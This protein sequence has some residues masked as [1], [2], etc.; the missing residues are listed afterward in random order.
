MEMTPDTDV[1]LNSKQQLLL[2]DCKNY[3][4]A[5]SVSKTSSIPPPPPI[6]KLVHGPPGVGK[7]FVIHQIV[8]A[9]GELGLEVGCCAYMGH[10]AT[11]MPFGRTVYNCLGI[12]VM[13]SSQ[14]YKWFSPSSIQSLGQTLSHLDRDKIGMIIIDEISMITPQFLAE[15]DNNKT[16]ITLNAVRS[17]YFAQIGGKIR[18]GWNC[19]LAKC[20]SQ[21]S[22]AQ[23]NQLY[24]DNI[25]LKDF[26]VPGAPG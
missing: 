10:P 24:R 5:L 8:S 18:I 2:E 23:T 9:A 4:R 19:P 20:S 7:S 11:N 3:F 12:P 17:K 22:Q 21:L 26:F 15:I 6:Y 13:E 14:M 1:Q 16:R 25:V